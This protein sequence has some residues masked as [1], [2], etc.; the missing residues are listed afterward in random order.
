VSCTSD[1]TLSGVQ[2]VSQKGMCVDDTSLFECPEKLLRNWPHTQEAVKYVRLFKAFRP[3]DDEATT[4]RARERF[5]EF[6]KSN[7]VKVLVGSQITCSTQDDEADWKQVQLLL[8]A[9]GKDHV[10]GLAVGNELD[11][12]RNVGAT[13]ECL[14]NIW[15]SYLMKSTQSRIQWARD[16]LGDPALPVTSVFTGAIVWNGELFDDTEFVKVHTYFKNVLDSGE[17]NYVFTFN[18]YPIFDGTNQPEPDGTC[19]KAMHASS[20][21]DSTD[22]LAQK[23]L[24]P[25]RQKLDR[26]V[27]LDPSWGIQSARFWIGELGWSSPQPTTYDGPMTTCSDFFSTQMLYSYYQKFMQWDLSIIGE[28]A[29]PEYVFYFTMRDASNY[30]HQEHF[31]LVQSCSSDACKL[32]SA[33]VPSSQLANASI[34]V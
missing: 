11:Q 7:N 18:F 9:L 31:G 12:L 26:F 4:S 17:R 22:C 20:C 1:L 21:Y 30:G 25:A 10:L 6:A 8:K 33:D 16:T 15:G 34:A 29:F 28:Q 3:D 2:K 23:N 13:A 14:D 27:Q 19:D 24:L 32:S 5:V